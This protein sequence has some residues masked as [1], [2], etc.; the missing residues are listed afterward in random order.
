MCEINYLLTYLQ[1]LDAL[2]VFEQL[3]PAVA[4]TVETIKNNVDRNWNAESTT[5]ANGLFH[6]LWL[7][8]APVGV[9]G[10]IDPQY[11]CLS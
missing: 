10:R 4:A 6:Q 2:D 1:R 7:H 8:H 5:K 3:L 11:S 9:R